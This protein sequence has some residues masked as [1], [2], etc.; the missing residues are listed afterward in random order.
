MRKNPT[1]FYDQAQENPDFAEQPESA[2][3]GMDDPLP[4]MRKLEAETVFLTFRL[5]HFLH[6][7]VSAAVKDTRV[8]KCALQS[9]QTYS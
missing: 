1:G 5:P 8:S 6:L 4:A 3:E 9:V 2:P 7:M